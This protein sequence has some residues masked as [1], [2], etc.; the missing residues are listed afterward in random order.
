M[1]LRSRHR[2]TPPRRESEHRDHDEIKRDA[3]SRCHA[4]DAHGV[5]VVAVMLS[6]VSTGPVEARTRWPASDDQRRKAFR[7]VHAEQGGYAVRGRSASA[8]SAVGQNIT[9]IMPEINVASLRV[10]EI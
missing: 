5:A 7:E 6:M 2:P 1:P 10:P 4:I 9:Y 3:G 8:A